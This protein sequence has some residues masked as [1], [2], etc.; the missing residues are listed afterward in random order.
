MIQITRTL[1]ATM[2]L[3]NKGKEVY[4][5]SK[6][7]SDKTMNAICNTP[8]NELEAS[9]FTFIPLMSPA[10]SNIKGYAVFFEGHLDEM[11]KILQ[12]KTGNKYQ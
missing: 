5:R 2:L 3:N 7:V 9:G 6:K 1:V 8:R 4:C 10:Y 12:Q 11:V